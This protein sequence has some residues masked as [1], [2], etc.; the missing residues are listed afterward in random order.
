[1][2]LENKSTL[3]PICLR[4]QHASIGRNELVQGK[5]ATCEQ[6][7][8]HLQ[9]TGIDLAQTCWI[10]LISRQMGCGYILWQFE[11]LL[12]YFANLWVNF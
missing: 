5:D 3:L 12:T 7:R 1:M 6:G 9:S 2:H 8:R 11:V 4:M 10:Y